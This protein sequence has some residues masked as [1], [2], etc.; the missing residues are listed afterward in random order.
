MASSAIKGISIE[1]GGNT[2]KLG[3][4]L[5]NVEK[6]SRSLT[7]ELKD[8]NG[9]L[10]FDPGNTELLAQKQKVLGD[11]IKECANKLDILKQAEKQ[12]QAQFERGEVTEEQYRALQ[13]EI[14]K[15]EGV[16]KGYGN[17]LE[18]VAKQLDLSS[19]GSKKAK[20]G[21]QETGDESKKAGKKL[22][23]FA[24]A[25]DK[26]NKS[27]GGLGKTL[28]GAAKTGLKAIGVA[29]GAAITG[30]VAAAES[31]REYRTEMGKL[32][33]AYS[34]SGHSADTASAAYKTLYGVIGET[35][36]SVEA[37][38]QI[39]LL[40]DSEK[41]VAKWADL[42]AG[43][44]GKFGDA[45]Q[46]ETFFESAN[47]TLKLGE[48]TGAFT[49]M[50]EGCGLSVE[51]F[52][53]GLAACTTEAEKQAYM[54]SVTEGALGEAGEA[55]KKNNAEI[56]R[57]NQANDAWMQS[58]AGVGGAIEPIITD[59]K[60]LGASLLSELVPGVQELAE[61]MRGL[62]NGDEGAAEAVGEALSG[63]ITQV[64]G[65]V[66]ELA[67]TLVSV[68]MSLI[69]TLTTTLINM[70]PQLTTTLIQLISTVLDGLTQAIP[71]IVQEFV[72][73]IPQLVQALVTG[74]PLL[75]Q[76][77]VQF[78]LAIVQ[79]IPQI[80]PPLVAAIPQ[81]TMALING[82]VAA[83]PALIQ[84]AVQF[85]MAIVQAI[86]QIVKALVPQIPV[87]VQTIVNCLQQ[88]LP[89]LL[90]GAIQ[91]FNAI[92]QAIPLILPPL[93][94]ALP[95]IINT[96]VNFL[97]NNIDILLDAAITLLFALIDAIPVLIEALV[98]NLPLIITTIIQALAN[99][100]PKV[101][102]AAVRLFFSLIDAAG[103]LL[104]QLP[105]MMINII[106]AIW[107]GLVS[108][109]PQILGA[110]VQIVGTILGALGELPLKV[111][112]IGKNIVKGIWDGICAMG[113][114]LWKKFTGWC[115]DLLGWAMKIL[116][117]HSPS[118]VFRD[119]IGKNIGLGMAEG[120]EDSMGAVQ[121]AVG[122]LGDTAINGID[123]ERELQNRS[124]QQATIQ[125]TFMTDSVAAKLDSI[126]AAIEKGQ[127]L[128]LDGKTLVGSTAGAYD[129]ALG[130]RRAL[131]AAGAL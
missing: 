74:I 3:K 83:I 11:A 70:L 84:G 88:N 115:D 41:D 12:V 34:A 123:L 36:Q 89:V 50:L 67:P 110:A 108:G 93:M 97:M 29:A 128:M 100:V 21:A 79:A 43:V 119:Q 118:R 71:Q 77:A 7:S 44:T 1:I 62:L 69:T 130:K 73:M 8:I 87:I 98:Q 46:P 117:I 106:T 86:P 125:H 22:D 92:I 54:L 75:I 104:S 13:R 91:L 96:L 61:A 113:D 127:V 56:I 16:M 53:A 19:K 120:I 58:L 126:L 103:Q 64:L 85:L 78:L 65:K 27:S 63:I 2:T 38:Q 81:I 102:Q 105:S 60:M 17:Q 99:A 57:A 72:A 24:D 90:Q 122:N 15:T 52:N 121:D 49:Q 35:D 20:K 94:Q 40:A 32:D 39:A 45:L 4:A 18:A 101:L 42:A 5:E 107:D 116:G 51:E 30:L 31:T 131:V 26:A 14:M 76:G 109:I 55:Y 111:L 25:A 28:A 9:M 68:A 6:K 129:N 114:W 33:A 10:K 47:E 112:D 82:L 66:T 124:V 95:Q 80:I 23:D 59:V 37:A 48:A